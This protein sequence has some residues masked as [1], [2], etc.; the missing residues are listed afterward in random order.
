MVMLRQQLQYRSNIHWRSDGD[1]LATIL[2]H[3][4]SYGIRSNN[5][6]PMATM[7]PPVPIEPLEIVVQMEILS[8]RWTENWIANGANCTNTPLLPLS[9]LDDRQWIT[10]VTIHLRMKILTVTPLFNNGPLLPLAMPFRYHQWRPMVI[11][12]GD[13]H[14][15]HLVMPSVIAAIRHLLYNQV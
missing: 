5:G 13:L 7:A 14:W 2:I 15:C 4:R 9:A 10:I 3:S 1:P 11:L 8:F 6:D 12:D